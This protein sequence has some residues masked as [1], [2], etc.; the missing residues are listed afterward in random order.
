MLPFER[1]LPS[2]LFEYGAFDKPI[3]AGVGGYA[4]E[5]LKEHLS[6]T[7]LFSPGDVDGFIR[8]LKADARPINQHKNIL[9]SPCDAVIGEFGKINDTELYQIKGFPYSLKDLL[10][11]LYLLFLKP[12][13]DTPFAFS[14]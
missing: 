13:V 9:T 4:A 6:N 1:V 14:F 7:I 10:G 5:F 2:K 11:N 8:E 12:I 3:I